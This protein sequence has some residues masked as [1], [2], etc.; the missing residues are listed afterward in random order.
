MDSQ[1]GY[2]LI[3][4]MV[5]RPREIAMFYTIKDGVFANRVKTKI[6]Y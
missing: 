6:F 5:N 3:T 4:F 2:G 1:L